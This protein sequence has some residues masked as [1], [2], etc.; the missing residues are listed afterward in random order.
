VF[1][2]IARSTWRDR[3]WELPDRT[4][5]F[6]LSITRLMLNSTLPRSSMQVGEQSYDLA[7]ALV[8]NHMVVLR[9]LLDKVNSYGIMQKGCNV[10]MF[11]QPVATCSYGNVKATKQSG[12][13]GV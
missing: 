10:G 11:G 7:L 1:R 6:S 12:T 4:E 5:K 8:G 13:L 2:V 9:R 3:R